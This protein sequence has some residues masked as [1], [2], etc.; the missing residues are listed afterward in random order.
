MIQQSK[1]SVK[2]H[3]Y[4]YTKYV[5][6]PNKMTTLI[7]GASGATGS[8]VV[9]QLLECG[10]SVK[11]IVR[12]AETLASHEN[13]TIIEA[14]LLDLSDDELA[15]HVKGCHAIVSCLGHNIS[16]KGLFGQPRKLV[17]EATQRLCEAVKTNK[18][19]GSVK[20]ILMN[21][22]GNSNR[23]LQEPISFAQKLVI[24]S[25][26]RLVPPHKDNEDAADYLR[27][28]IDRSNKQLEWVAVR[29]DSLL[30]EETISAYTVHAS[31]TRSAIFNP[32]KTSR[33]NVAQFMA[34]LITKQETWNK[35]KYQMPVIYNQTTE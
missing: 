1:N 31:P 34:E 33:I 14:S 18:P 24:S 19:E 12:S 29:P 35:W 26:R 13:L 2:V 6:L 9:N 3:L 20:F 5:S 4:E 8:L 16:F 11:A 25:L 28:E 17:T 10:Q 27:T 7:V 23:D 21:T 30:N 15:Q 22:V 32:G